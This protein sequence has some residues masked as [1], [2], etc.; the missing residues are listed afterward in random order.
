MPTAPLLTGGPPSKACLPEACAS[1]KPQGSVCD[2]QDT[3]AVI[4]ERRVLGVSPRRGSLSAADT[5]P[6]NACSLFFSLLSISS[7]SPE[8]NV[9]VCITKI[10]SDSLIMTSDENHPFSD[11]GN[12]RFPPCLHVLPAGKQ[13]QLA[14]CWP[15]VFAAERL[16]EVLQPLTKQ[17]KPNIEFKGACA[18]KDFS[19]LSVLL[20]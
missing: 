5:T 19:S 20:S 7:F 1:L 13:R 6:Q 3:L 9:F 10:K 12:V 8:V 14:G 15:R 11:L 18:Q 16:E 2:L 4:S 17:K